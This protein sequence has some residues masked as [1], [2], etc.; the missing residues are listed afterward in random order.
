MMR[1]PEVLLHGG[2]SS[3]TGQNLTVLALYL[4]IHRLKLATDVGRFAGSK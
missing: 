4:Q 1:L 3:P 2:E